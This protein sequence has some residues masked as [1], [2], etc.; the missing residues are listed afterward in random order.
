MARNMTIMPAP[1]PAIVMMIG[2]SLPL[3]LFG[4]C[5]VYESA[6]FIRMKCPFVGLTNT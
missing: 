2:H 4:L 5:K 6:S 3:Y 1:A